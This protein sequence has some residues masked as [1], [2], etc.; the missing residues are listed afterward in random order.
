[1]SNLCWV[2]NDLGNLYR[3]AG[4]K[5]LVQLSRPRLSEGDRLGWFYYYLHCYPIF[6][7][8]VY[9]NWFYKLISGCFL[10]F[11]RTLEKK[12]AG[13]QWR[14]EGGHSSCVI[15]L[16]VSLSLNDNCDKLSIVSKCWQQPLRLPGRT[17]EICCRIKKQNLHLLTCAA[18][19]SSLVMM[20]RTRW[21][22]THCGIQITDKN[23]K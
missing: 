12:T 14:L 9:I 6:C 22:L 13:V 19:S 3:Q 15:Q 4:P 1:M 18:R 17:K 7:N 11:T 8:S 16:S 21:S 5:W 10:P 23:L 2:K 20:M